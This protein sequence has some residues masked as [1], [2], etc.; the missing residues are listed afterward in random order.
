MAGEEGGSGV[1]GQGEDVLEG[2]ECGVG[3]EL[4]GGGG[5]GG[6]EERVEGHT[7]ELLAKGPSHRIHWQ[8]CAGI[9]VYVM[10]VG[11]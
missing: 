6:Q 10:Y 7:E 1:F 9:A 8:S 2:Q 11:K 4:A 3:G 5:G